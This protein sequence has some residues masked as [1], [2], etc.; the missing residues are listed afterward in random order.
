MA[1]NVEETKRFSAADA[2][3]LPLFER[4]LAEMVQSVIPVVQL[5]RARSPAC[6]R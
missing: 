3:A 5:D 2:A 6:G 4:D 1:A